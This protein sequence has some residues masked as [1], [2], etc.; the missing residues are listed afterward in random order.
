[1]LEPFCR[2][3]APSSC[4][5]SWDWPSLR[6]GLG[7]GAG[8]S[9]PTVRAVA[10]AQPLFPRLDPDRQQELLLKWREARRAAQACWRKRP[11]PSQ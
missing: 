8:A 6:S 5:A 7:L 11:R 2:L 9:Y 3:S 1:M 4:A 10:K